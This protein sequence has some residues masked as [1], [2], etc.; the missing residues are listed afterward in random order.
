MADNKWSLLINFLAAVG[1]LI[2]FF[3]SEQYLYVRIV[4]LTFA[5]TEPLF[6]FY[7][8]RLKNS[9]LWFWGYCSL[10]MFGVILSLALDHQLLLTA[11]TF[12][13][14][15]FVCILLISTYKSLFPSH[16]ET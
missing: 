13:I 1:I 4:V 10:N 16:N 8:S 6:L 14:F 15:A 5:V 11:N 2:S 9:R 7:H 12:Y 3:M